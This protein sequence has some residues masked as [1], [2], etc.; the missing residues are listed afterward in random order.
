M[1][2]MRITVG[3]YAPVWLERRTYRGRELKAST[4]YRLQCDIRNNIIPFFGNVALEEVTQ[5]LIDEWLEKFPQD[6]WSRKINSYKTLRAILR[7]A[8]N[9]QEDGSA[10]LISRFPVVK[11][12]SR[13][14]RKSQSVPATDE[15]LKIIYENMPSKYAVS[16]YLA[17]FAAMR[18]GEICGLKRK[19]FNTDSRTVFICRARMTQGEKLTDVPKSANSVRSVV[20]PENLMNSIETHLRV[21][22]TA[23]PEAWV[24]PSPNKPLKPVHPNNLRNVFAKARKAAGREDLRFHDLRHT[25]LTWLAI[26]GATVKELM[27]VAGHSDPQV[28]ME[29]QHSVSARRRQL[30]DRMG[31]H[32]QKTGEPGNA[33]TRIRELDRQIN[34]LM[35]QRNLLYEQLQH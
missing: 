3:E 1:V 28:A 20:L 15:Q 11:S 32:L 21:H 23:G 6:Q 34:E 35:E 14:K 2:S 16:V 18:I 19:D 22:V 29:Y 26:E 10:P 12:L 25:A 9:V 17:A 24:F 33:M 5:Q 13:P 27:D 4:K 7:S 31:T 30:A 8:A